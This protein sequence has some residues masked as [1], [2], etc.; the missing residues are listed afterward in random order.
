MLQCQE[1]ACFTQELSSPWA[2][3]SF[4]LSFPLSY[5]WFLFFHFSIMKCRMAWILKCISRYVTLQCKGKLEWSSWLEEVKGISRRKSWDR[6][7]ILFVCFVLK[8]HIRTTVTPRNSLEWHNLYRQGGGFQH[9]KCKLMTQKNVYFNV[10]K[11]ARGKQMIS[12]SLPL[13]M[14]PCPYPSTHTNDRGTLFSQTMVNAQTGRGEG[15]ARLDA[16]HSCLQPQVWQNISALHALRNCISFHSTWILL[17]RLLGRLF[18]L[19]NIPVK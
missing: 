16:N 12:M 18:Y 1:I 11:T 10:K 19:H 9:T 3:V 5:P 6:A 15:G 13:P 4:Q 17:R 7:G 2:S 14:I 8:G